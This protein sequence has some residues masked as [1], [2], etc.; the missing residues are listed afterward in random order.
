MAGQGCRGATR[1]VIAPPPA[2]ARRASSPRPRGAR[3]ACARWP[4]APAP[5]TAARCGARAAAPTCGSAV[6]TT[7]AP[8]R[9]R[10]TAARRRR[11]VRRCSRPSRYAPSPPAAPVRLVAVPPLSHGGARIAAIAPRGPGSPRAFH[12]ARLAHARP[13]DTRPRRARR[14]LRRARARRRAWAGVCLSAPFCIFRPLRRDAQGARGLRHAGAAPRPD[15]APVAMRPARCWGVIH[16]PCSRTRPPPS[17]PPSLRRRERTRRACTSRSRA[18]RARCASRRTRRA[19]RRARC[20]APPV[21][22]TTPPRSSRARAAGSPP[23]RRLARPAL[24]APRPSPFSSSARSR[25]STS[26]ATR[27]RAT[28]GARRPRGVVARPGTRGVGCG[29]AAGEPNGGRT[30]FLRADGTWAGHADCAATPLCMPAVEAAEREAHCS[31]SATYYV[32]ARRA[33]WR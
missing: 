26:R 20:A 21:G 28:R 15:P 8:T 18:R 29:H 14:R 30:V 6:P 33:A 5:T 13:H 17:P 25:C 16:L 19:N 7:A 9:P 27:S 12:P 32:C 3:C 4:R 1:A 24:R 2:G 31:A 22:T 10:R 23:P 11:R